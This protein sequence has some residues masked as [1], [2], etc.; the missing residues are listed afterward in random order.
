MHYWPIKSLFLVGLLL[1]TVTARSEP[2]EPP[3][4]KHQDNIE[5][6]LNS[7]PNDVNQLLSS[8]EKENESLIAQ[9]E[10]TP[11][12]RRVE[13]H[14]KHVNQKTGLN[15]G[16]DYVPLYEHAMETS[17]KQNA[18]GGE[19]HLF[20]KWNFLNKNPRSP[21]IGFKIE[22]KHR[23]TQ[24]YP[25]QLAEQFDSIIK[26]VSGYEQLNTAITELWLQSFL[27]KDIIAFRLGKLELTSIMNSYAFDSRRFY[28]LSDVFSSSPAIN[29]PQKGLGLI[30]AFKITRHVYLGAGITD[31]NGTED[32][33]G[34]STL[35]H[36]E[37]IKALE[38]GYRDKI[39]NPQSDNYH[40]FV[41]QSDAQ[42]AMGIP[43]DHG[44][45]F[46]LQ[47]NFANRFIP[48]FKANFN[49]GRVKDIKQLYTS[50]FGY[51]YPF[52]GKFGLLGFAVGYAALSDK[53]SG[54][55]VILESFYRI[56]LT[57]FS[58]L[59][60]DIQMIYTPIPSRWVPVI[61]LRFRTALG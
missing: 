38:L 10:F 56:Q 8:L 44:F 49:S 3:G 16:M 11:F 42:K 29:R 25:G 35:H 57:P 27:I 2:E 51:H 5:W 40:V 60:P 37:F 55:Q 9:T 12:F 53:Q 30:T 23:Y 32:S 6:S 36:G 41:W 20:G 1:Y 17:E 54:H 34:F 7:S 26:T 48:F 43:S 31:L 24:I 45:S 19:L 13:Q 50:G 47:K 18:S 39:V 52:N 46:V 21:M 28:F 33:S 4:P 22:E 58:Q 61:N 59:T 14:M 15:I